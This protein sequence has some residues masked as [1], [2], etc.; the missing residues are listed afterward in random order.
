M[1]AKLSKLPNIGSQTELW[2]RAIGINSLADLEAMGATTP[3]ADVVRTRMF[4]VDVD[5][6]PA[7]VQAHG[8]FFGDVR[9]ATTLVEVARLIEPGLLVEIEA[10]AVMGAVHEND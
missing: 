2:L 10:D 1:P 6:W 5:D 8:Q 9:P 7:I 3:I 4:V